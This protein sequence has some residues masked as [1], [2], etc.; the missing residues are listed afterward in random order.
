MNESIYI[1]NTYVHV[2]MKNASV[3]EHVY[4]MLRRE[5]CRANV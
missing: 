4:E 5:I 3:Y 1:M 2:L